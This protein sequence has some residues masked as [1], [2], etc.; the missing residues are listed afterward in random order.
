MLTK[1][2]TPNSNLDFTNIYEALRKSEE[3]G[4]II[5][6]EEFK[7]FHVLET[8]NTNYSKEINTILTLM[9]I[10]SRKNILPSDLLL[11]F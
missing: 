10:V 3:K 9:Y 6:T 1:D 2:F 11:K 8:M 7:K 4:L 5:E